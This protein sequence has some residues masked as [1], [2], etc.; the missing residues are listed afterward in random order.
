MPNLIGHKDKISEQCLSDAV[1]YRTMKR[2]NI[3]IFIFIQILLL[4]LTPIYA[5]YY[6]SGQDAAATK[7]M[8]IKTDKVRIVFPEPF[9]HIAYQLANKSDSLFTATAN[10]LEHR[11]RRVNILLHTGD[12]ISNGFTSWAPRRIEIYTTPPQDVDGNPWL[13]HVALHEY[14]HF[15]QVDMLNRGITRTLSNIFGDQAIGA[16]LG[17]YVPLWFLEGD[18]VV[19]ETALSKSGRGRIPSFGA[20]LRAQ[21]EDKGIFDYEKAYFGSYRDFVPNHYIL[22]YH[23]VASTRLKYSPEIWSLGLDRIARRPWSIRPLSNI[24]KGKTGNNLQETYL[25]SML[26]W[27]ERWKEGEP[28]QEVG[29]QINGSYQKTYT[30]Y[31]RP[32]PLPDGSIV[33]E[34]SGLDDIDRIVRIDSKGDETV[35][36]SPGSWL[37]N[38]LSVSASKIAW[39]ER[40][41]HPRW[42]NKAWAEIYV[43]DIARGKKKRLTKKGRYFSPAISP[44]EKSIAA[45]TIGENNDYALVSLDTE[46]GELGFIRS[47]PNT[48]S[49]WMYPAWHPDGNKIVVVAQYPDGRKTL[50]LIDLV[51]GQN[52]ELIKSTHSDINYPSVSQDQVWFSGTQSGEDVIYRV[53]LDCSGLVEMVEGRF[54]YTDPHIDAAGKVLCVS[55]YTSNGYK[56]RVINV[57]QLQPKAVDSAQ[58]EWIKIADALSLQEAD[59]AKAALEYPS[60]SVKPYRKL[61]HLFNLHSWAPVSINVDERAVNPGVSFFS[62]NLLNTSFLEAGYT[63]FPS[64]ERGEYF[65]KY[66]YQGFLPRFLIEYRGTHRSS[67]GETPEGEIRAFSYGE[68]KWRAGLDLPLRFTSGP[69]YLGLLPSLF[70][71]YTKLSMDD[72]SPFEFRKNRIN[73]LDYRIYAYRLMKQS[74]RDLQS[75]WG[76]VLEINFRND[77]WYNAGGNIASIEGTAYVPGIL[78][79]HGITLYAGYQHKEQ[80][81]YTYSNTIQMPTGWL[82]HA[83]PEFWSVSALYRLPLWYPDFNIPGIIYAKRI[84]AA[85]FYDLARGEYPTVAFD[86][87]SIGAELRLD[88]HLFRFIAPFDLGYRWIWRPEPRKLSGEF[89]MSINFS[90]F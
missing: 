31:R 19:A 85:L 5:Q 36:V 40:R 67:F 7:W 4:Q 10:S 12:I 8:Q 47:Q 2:F 55:A 65:T 90:D 33:A 32:H 28:L 51:S 30:D 42:E 34:R 64:E 49:H 71:S 68:D 20:P 26:D 84:K 50:L 88:A 80:G 82:S 23:L 89:L 75:R 14:R 3:L 78:K 62:Q 76:Q 29:I 61:F 45:I 11:P 21:L 38:S 70:L 25:A 39:I 48:Y 79:H 87:E 72:E 73:S 60:Y 6:S 16:V 27:R 58:N 52:T 41:P 22:G 77:P 54:G 59:A 66:T 18:A 86:Y 53:N 83:E 1:F 69:Y 44:D 37:R 17:L 63:Y 35:I 24:I 46:S 15:V 56:I 74:S 9:Q 43:Y 57:D 81:Q 13:H